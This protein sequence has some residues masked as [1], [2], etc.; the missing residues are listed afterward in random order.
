MS[1]F[2]ATNSTLWCQLTSY[3]KDEDDSENEPPA[4]KP[5][6]SS[7][8]DSAETLRLYFTWRGRETSEGEIHSGSTGGNEGTIEF[9]D[10]KAIQFKGL[11]SFP[12]LGDKCHFTGTKFDNDTPKA[13]E[14]WSAFSNEAAE[15]ARVHRWN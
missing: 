6:T 8:L 14:A 3:A 10:E 12:A 7:T 5:K 4:K 9:H 11:G 2:I 15:R 1:S 13:P